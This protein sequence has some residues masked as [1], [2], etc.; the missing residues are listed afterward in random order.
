MDG[1]L[2]KTKS[3]LLNHRAQYIAEYGELFYCSNPNPSLLDF[4]ELPPSPS[5]ILKLPSQ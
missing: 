3:F 2:S 1:D 4:V 5:I